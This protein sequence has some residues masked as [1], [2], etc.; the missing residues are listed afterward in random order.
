M[1]GVPPEGQIVFSHDPAAKIRTST[2]KGILRGQDLLAAYEKLFN[3]PGFDPQYNDLIDLRLIE[4]ME[5]T[6][7]DLRPFVAKVR[8][9]D[10]LGIHTRV[11]IV[12][13]T[14]HAY[15]AGRL[16]EAMR[17]KDST[18]FIALFHSM[19]NALLWLKSG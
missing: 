8:Q 10:K 19:E 11:A 15:G 3:S 2:F 18:E 12:A 6:T 4:K 9:L 5:V 1:T 13:P 17:G 7:D 14:D 16:Y